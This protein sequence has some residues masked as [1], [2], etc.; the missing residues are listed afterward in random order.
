MIILLISWTFIIAVGVAI[1]IVQNINRNPKT[2]EQREEEAKLLSQG[3]TFNK[4]YP[5]KDQ[6]NKYKGIIFTEWMRYVPD[7]IRFNYINHDGSIAQ[8]E[9]WRGI[10]DIKNLSPMLKSLV[11]DRD[12]S[13]KNISIH[14]KIQN[15]DFRFVIDKE[16]SE[17]CYF[18]I[19]NEL[20]LLLTLQEIQQLQKLID[21]SLEEVEFIH[22]G[23]L[24]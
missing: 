21:S 22:M 9:S 23:N 11:S 6:T 19:S 20:S 13:G 5:Y 1:S 2:Q 14:Q 18:I 15:F 17:K 8:I 3:F 7:Y 10:A 4:L 24:L 12:D 16:P